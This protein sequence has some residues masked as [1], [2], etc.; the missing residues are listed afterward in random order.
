QMITILRPTL[1]DVALPVDY[2]DVD[3]PSLDCSG[4]PWDTNGDGYPQVGEVDGPTV[5]GQPF[6]NGDLCDIT[7]TYTDQVIDICPGSFKI[8]RKWSIIDWC[9]GEDAEHNQIIKVLDTHGPSVVCPQGPVT[10]NVY[11]GGQN[12]NGPHDV[13]T[14]YVTIPPLQIL[15][16]DCSGVNGGAHV[17]E[18]WTL[19]AGQ[20]IK[21]IPGNG[22]TFSDIELIADNPPTN[23]AQYTIRHRIYD[24]CGNVTDC[25]Y[26]IT[27]VDKVPPVA[28]CD[29][30]T[31][32]AI[33]N[34]GPS[35]QGCSWLPAE[36]LDDGSYDNC[37]DVWFYAAKMN[38]FL[39][40]PYFYQYYPALQYCCDDIGEQ[41]VILLVLDFD[42][43]PFALPDGSIFLLPGQSVFEGSFNTC[44]VTVNVNDKLPP[45]TTFCPGPQTI[46]CDTYLDNYAAAL[47]AGNNSVLDV[48]GTATFFDNCNLDITYNVT[49]NINTCQEGTI[50]RSWTADDGP[51][52]PNASCTQ[53][54]TVTHKS[55]WVVEFPADVTAQCV[56]GQLPD[57]GEPQIFHD[58]CELIGV[59]YEDQ[60]FYVV[61][62]A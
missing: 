9:A 36:S 31:D 6:V 53:V 59:S 32:L 56:D 22:G 54:I 58:E 51:T 18:I 48:F 10:I 28:I 49:V 57:F 23:N 3:A 38:P 42:P 12:T 39:Q 24:N 50:V 7:S 35:G 11:A 27:V 2:D 41:M 61:V 13:C 14:G 16:D 25:L 44:M 40:P 46:D 29:E 55:D 60:Y 8:L 17:T 1:A 15:G 62:D 45:V 34:N 5:Y 4:S 37:G 43:T 26:N 30:I 21:T 52:N 20:L 19:G 33:T 47:A